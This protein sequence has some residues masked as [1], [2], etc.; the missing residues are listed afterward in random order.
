MLQAIKNHIT[1]HQQA[2]KKAYIAGNTAAIR[3]HELQLTR[4]YSMYELAFDYLVANAAEMDT[5]TLL[6]KVTI[7]SSYYYVP[8][9]NGGYFRSCKLTV[10]VKA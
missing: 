9:V 6:E 7:E 8:T 2:L 4:L 1:Y 10:V 3:W 5:D